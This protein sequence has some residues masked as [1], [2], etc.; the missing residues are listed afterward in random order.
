MMGPEAA[1][2]LGDCPFVDHAAIPCFMRAPRAA[3]LSIQTLLRSVMTCFQ[4]SICFLL[5]LLLFAPSNLWAA[6]GPSPLEP[7]IEGDPPT[8]V[9]HLRT[10][11]RANATTRQEV[12]LTDV[13]SLG[14]CFASCTVQLQ[15]LGQQRI[16][17]QIDNTTG[18][19]PLLDLNAL[20]PDLLRIYHTGR[21]DAVRLM[22]LSAIMG[23]AN[24]AAIESLITVPSSQSARVRELTHRVVADFFVNVYPE[25]LREGQQ[26]RSVSLDEVAEL[27]GERT[28]LARRAARRA[29]KQAK[30]AAK[31]AEK[32][33]AQA[34]QNG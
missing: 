26:I 32:A 18:V 8:L 34:R 24:E 27:R 7:E 31:E 16:R 5:L 1:W 4:R 22:A 2:L 29:A 13:I 25:L 28:R 19:G 23:L 10:E 9:G 20:S 14:G 6:P 15:S 30:R 21:T 3:V 17:L 11:L 12:A 33:A